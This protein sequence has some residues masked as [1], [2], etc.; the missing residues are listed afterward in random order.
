MAVD[1]AEMVLVVL[2]EV[3]IV[4]AGAMFLGVLRM[5]GN[6]CDYW[7]TP[8]RWWDHYWTTMRGTKGCSLHCDLQQDESGMAPNSPPQNAY[9]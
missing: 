8:F 7:Q 1:D 3:V 5:M 6:G 2:V 9:K 4:V